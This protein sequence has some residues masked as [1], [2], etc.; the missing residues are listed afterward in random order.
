MSILTR[1]LKPERALGPVVS[2]AWVRVAAAHQLG[3]GEHDLVLRD[4]HYC[5]LHAAEIRAACGRAWMPWVVERWDCDE[6]AQELIQE[7]K[8]E[9]RR[10]AI[11]AG[12][13]VGMMEARAP[14]GVWH[15][16]VVWLCAE[17]LRFRFY[18]ATAQKADVKFK[19][20]RLLIL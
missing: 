19:H 2:A 20:P 1:I 15:A 9:R 16:Y 8:R 18:D 5:A 12:D 14:S 4:N 3:L 17:T 13:A 11:G 7:V 10:L 6:Q